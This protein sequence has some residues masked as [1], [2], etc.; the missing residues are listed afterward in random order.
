MDQKMITRFYIPYWICHRKHLKPNFLAI[1]LAHITEVV[2]NVEGGGRR[3]VLQLRG[4]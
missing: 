4:P 1:Y 3:H 2:L